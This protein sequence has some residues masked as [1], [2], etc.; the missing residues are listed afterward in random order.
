ML[1][2]RAWHGDS[3][4]PPLP[5]CQKISKPIGKSLPAQCYYAKDDNLLLLP[6]IQLAQIAANYGVN[7]KFQH[8]QWSPTVWFVKKKDALAHFSRVLKT[9]VRLQS[10]DFQSQKM[11]KSC[12]FTLVSV[13]IYCNTVHNY[14]IIVLFVLWDSRIIQSVY[15]RNRYFFFQ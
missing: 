10:Q 3:Q 9:F 4:L 15:S 11:L 2:Y 5:C 8:S 7:Y 14:I 6:F 13:C 1:P 12:H